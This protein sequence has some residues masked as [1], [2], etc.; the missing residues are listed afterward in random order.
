MTRLQFATVAY[1]FTKR[2]DTQNAPYPIRDGQIL[3]FQV[4]W[5]Y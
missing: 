4:Q 3:R 1:V 2:T 5:N